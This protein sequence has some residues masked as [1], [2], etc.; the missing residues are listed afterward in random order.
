M[1]AAIARLAPEAL[2]SYP[3][4]AASIAIRSTIGGS[5]RAFYIDAGGKR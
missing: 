1:Q 2:A 4:V 3:R 5:I